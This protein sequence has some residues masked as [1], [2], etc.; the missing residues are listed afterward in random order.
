VSWHSSEPATLFLVCVN[1][2]TSTVLTTALT[3]GRRP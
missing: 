1:L 3:Q 2:V